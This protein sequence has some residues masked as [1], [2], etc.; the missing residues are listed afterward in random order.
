MS[1][2]GDKYVETRASFT[3]EQ[4]ERTNRKAIRDT[5]RSANLRNDGTPKGKPRYVKRGKK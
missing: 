4:A 2:F 5:L 3:E 1:K